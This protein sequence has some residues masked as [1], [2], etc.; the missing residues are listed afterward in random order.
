MK[1]GLRIG[2]SYSHE[3]VVTDAMKA[4]FGDVVVHP[5]YSTAA[6]VQ[7]MEWACRQLVLPYYETEEDGAGYHVSV[8]HIR[9]TPIGATVLIKAIVTGFCGAKI[10]CQCFAYSLEQLVGRGVVTQ[11]VLPRQALYDR[12]PP[13]Q[14]TP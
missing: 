9:P 11:A 6:M 13:L 7:H 14:N 5:L 2:E 3:L 1:P 4:Q 8:E 12:I 10:T